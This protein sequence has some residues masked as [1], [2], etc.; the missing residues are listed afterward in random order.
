MIGRRC[1]NRD[2]EKEWID[3][4]CTQDQTRDAPRR[5]EAL[6]PQDRFNA[7]KLATVDQKHSGPKTRINGPEIAVGA[8]LYGSLMLQVQRKEN[9]NDGRRKRID[10]IYSIIIR[11]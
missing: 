8:E 6:S 1:K 11:E 7:R 9:K 10:T 2:P 5:T 4:N 3:E